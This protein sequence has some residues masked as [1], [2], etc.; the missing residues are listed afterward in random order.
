MTPQGVSKV[1]RRL[2]EE[3]RVDLFTR[4]QKGI[5]MTEYGRVFL[6]RAEEIVGIA[7]K[8][9]EELAA[10]KKQ[11]EGY[12]RLASAY[13]ILRFLTPDF[14][15]SFTEQNKELHLDYSEAPDS[16]V[17][18]MVRKGEA[19]VA[20]VPYLNKEE[21][22]EY[23]PLFEKEIYFITHPGSRFYDLPEVSIK[24]VM[25]EPFVTETSNF[26]IHHIIEDTCRQGQVEPDIYFNT[27]G[28]SLCYKLCREGEANTASMDFIFDD[29]G[30]EGMRKIPL[31]EH[32]V[33]PVALVFKK[34]S[35]RSENLKKFGEFAED[36]CS[37]LP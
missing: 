37:T 23:V 33:W 1:V 4:S 18:D 13:G 14:I 35:P 31:C 6:P 24:D 15:R 26:L 21:D 10:L 25:T 16:F 2:E 12:L 22:L 19:D 27:S 32:P 34:D 9:E 20:M 36:W 7:E 3:L 5:Q 8:T 29:M 30:T 11:N 28:F 17:I